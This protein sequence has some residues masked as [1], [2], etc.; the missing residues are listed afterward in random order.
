MVYLCFLE[1]VCDVAESRG[2]VSAPL[3]LLGCV[4]RSR[5]E[6]PGRNF[7]EPLQ[8]PLLPLHPQAGLLQDGRTQKMVRIVFKEVF[9]SLILTG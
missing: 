4:R 2:Q 7:E 3:R 6:G 5:E 1:G 8:G 9:G